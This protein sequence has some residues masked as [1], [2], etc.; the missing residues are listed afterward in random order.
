[1]GEGA[2]AAAFVLVTTTCSLGLGRCFGWRHC[3]LS[4]V[5]GEAAK[6]AKHVGIRCEIRE[7]CRRQGNHSCAEIVS[8]SNH[9]SDD[10]G[11]GRHAT[12]TH[13]NTSASDH[14]D[15][16]NNGSDPTHTGSC[17]APTRG[18]ASAGASNTSSDCCYGSA[19]TCTDNA[20]S[21][22]CCGNASTCTDNTSSGYCCGIAPD[23]TDNTSSACCSAHRS[24]PTAPTSFDP[25][26]YDA[27]GHD[28]R[29]CASTRSSHPVRCKQYKP[30]SNS[31]GVCGTKG[32]SGWHCVW[33]IYRLDA[34]LLEKTKP[35]RHP[36][37]CGR[38]GRSAC[39]SL[40][41]SIGCRRQ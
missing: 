36:A 2:A 39:R 24:C 7:P 34:L 25:G 17:A 11:S 22:C 9:T 6:E 37:A 38:N 23:C 1:V 41:G 19:P 35:W 27:S 31:T 3:G 13:S 20:S 32:D 33:F 30:K 28:G 4:V 10:T 29:R 15:A 12:H 16:S 18:S 40:G 5:E 26:L 8:N 21:G 14:C